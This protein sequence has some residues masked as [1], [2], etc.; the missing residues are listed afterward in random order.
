MP[1]FVIPT[2][3]PSPAKQPE[4]ASTT[5]RAAHQGQND[6]SRMLSREIAQ[7]SADANAAAA[8]SSAPNANRAAATQQARPDGDAARTNTN[9]NTSAKG[10]ANAVQGDQHAAQETRDAASGTEKTS[11]ADA[12]T[13]GAKEPG[14]D[15]DKDSGKDGKSALDTPPGAADQLLALAAQ[16]GKLN[17]SQSAAI[18]TTTAADSA[19][20]RAA[21]DAAAGPRGL[22]GDAA[23]P[24]LDANGKP[25]AARSAAPGKDAPGAMA[26][27][28]VAAANA[29]AAAPGAAQSASTTGISPGTFVAAMANADGKAATE[30]VASGD[31]LLAANGPGAAPAPIALAGAAAA[32][33]ATGTIAAASGAS[34][35]K[36]TPTVGRNGWDQALGQRVVWMVSGGEQSA[37]LSLNPPDLGPLQVVLNISQG[38]ATASFTAAQPEV[39]QALEAAMPR[40]RE[41]LG[42]AGINLG[43]ANVSAGTPQQQQG[44]FAQQSPSPRDTGPGGPNTDNRIGG[45]ERVVAP[46]R[47]A[48]R[49]G[50]VDTFA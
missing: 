20:D 24:A 21:A 41:M 31:A 38:H 47:R 40:L 44:G 10:D 32:A 36:L 16:I 39:R 45:V 11:A 15:S 50:M 13:S 4:R 26:S 6:F 9:T 27:V 14:K 19:V 3:A 49:D 43:Q 7:G 29:V 1:A 48:G 12:R 33:A 37:S 46:A 22:P 17:Q 5:A 42:E 25:L 8:A 18:A 23:G 28:S 34:R 30:G 2:A 35:D